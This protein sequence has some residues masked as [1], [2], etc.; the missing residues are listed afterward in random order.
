MIVELT[1][2]DE[3][4]A[5]TFIALTVGGLPEGIAAAG[6]G[7][8]GQCLFSAADHVWI[9]GLV[10]VS[11]SGTDGCNRH[12]EYGNMDDGRIAGCAFH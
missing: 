1:R 6:L 11:L 2:I 8:R 7:D 12:A 4:V 5:L 10:G 9:L 3:L